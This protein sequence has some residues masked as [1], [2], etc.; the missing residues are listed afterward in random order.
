MCSQS[1]PHRLFTPFFPSLDFT[2]L[3]PFFFYSP[4]PYLTTSLHL[5]FLHTLLEEPPPVVVGCSSR[6]DRLFYQFPA[7]SAAVRPPARSP[8]ARPR[9]A[10]FANRNIAAVLFPCLVSR[11]GLSMVNKTFHSSR[12]IVSDTV[13][14]GDGGGQWVAW[15]TAQWVQW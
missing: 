12:A 2:H 15:S 4:S 10:Y 9:H 8:P 3:R 11:R 7:L 6:S 13:G 14:A 5:D 1:L